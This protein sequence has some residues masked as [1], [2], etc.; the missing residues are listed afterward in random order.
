MFITCIIL[1]TKDELK[2][3]SKEA[4][5]DYKAAL[6]TEFHKHRTGVQENPFQHK[7]LKESSRQHMGQISEQLNWIEKHS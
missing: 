6:V 7:D 4:R 5:E 1:K 3:L 2:K